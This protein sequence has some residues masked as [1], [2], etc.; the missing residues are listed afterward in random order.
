MLV[1]YARISTADQ[2]LD[3]QLDAL[4]SA[5]CER[6][7]T[8][9]ASGANTQRPGLAELLDFIR[10]DDTLV[11]WKLDRLGR[12]LP[13]LL[14]T[15]TSLRDRG[16]AFR[17]LQES[18]DTSSPTGNLIFNVFG[19]LA[20]FEREIIR[21]RT[22]AGLAAARARGR[23]GGRARALTEAKIAQAIAMRR[24]PS[25]TVDGI[26]DTL[27]ISRATFYRHVATAIASHQPSAIAS[28]D[29]DGPRGTSARTPRPR[30]AS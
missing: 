6:T 28:P 22:H 10:P 7:F 16:V 20:Q 3:L 27:G 23:S 30:A 18:L 19:S 8:D 13:H 11:V 5:G 4:E 26:C 29:K 24:D 25:S 14:E 9:V 21:E 12:S 2:N 17:S 15:V 1:G